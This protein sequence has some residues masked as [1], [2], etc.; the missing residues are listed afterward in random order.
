[1]ALTLGACSPRVPLYRAVVASEMVR[2]PEASYIDGQQGKL[3]WNYTTGLELAAMLDVYTVMVSTETVVGS[4]AQKSDNKANVKNRSIVT[5]SSDIQQVAD[6]EQDIL[7]P[8]KATAEEIINYVDAWYDAIIDEEGKI[9]KYKKSN[10]SLDHICPG[11]TLFGLY[12]LTGKEKYRRAMDTLYS[13][14]KSQPRTAEG[15]FWHKQVYPNQMWLDGL[16][17]AQPFYAE[18]TR[19]YVKDPEERAANFA[20]IAQQFI[21]VAEHTWDPATQ[22]YRHAWDSSHQM[23]WCNPETGQSDHAWGRALG[24]YMMALVDVLPLLPAETPGRDRMLEIY[25]GLCETLPRYADPATGM[26]YQVL[27]RPGEK[28][29]YVEATASAMFIY[30]MAKGTRFGYIGSRGYARKAYKKLQKTFVS[31]K[32]GLVSLDRCCEVAGLGGKENRRG[33][34]DYYINEKIRSND[35]KGIGPLIWAALELEQH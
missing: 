18:Y 15:G 6:D 23:F 33:D 9:Y 13:Q 30:S 34:Y 26:W 28:G 20:D 5:G 12:D 19:R 4:G 17:M 14:L 35:P 3:K 2:N 32:D 22:L 27:D 24:W 8:K 7:Q 10:Y 1:M 21:I 16:Y 25:K 31:R 11:R 29:N